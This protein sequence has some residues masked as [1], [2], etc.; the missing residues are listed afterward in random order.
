MHVHNMI[1]P[2]AK[3]VS[4][5]FELF[6]FASLRCPL[7]F[8]F[9]WF[10]PRYILTVIQY[11]QH[12]LQ[13]P[14]ACQRNRKRLLQG[15][16]SGSHIGLSKKIEHDWI[17]IK[18]IINSSNNYQQ[19]SRKHLPLWWCQSKTHLYAM[20]GSMAP[21]LASA[22]AGQ[23][24]GANLPMGSTSSALA[25]PPRLADL[26][27]HGGVRGRDQMVAEFMTLGRP[28]MFNPWNWEWNGESRIFKFGI[29]WE[30]FGMTNGE[31]S[32]WWILAILAARKGLEFVL[33]KDVAH[34]PSFRCSF[35]GGSHKTR[36]VSAWRALCSNVCGWRSSSE[37]SWPGAAVSKVRHSSY[38]AHL[39]HHVLDPWQDFLSVYHASCPPW[40]FSL[41]CGHRSPFL[42]SPRWSCP[43]FSFRTSCSSPLNLFL[44]EWN[45]CLFGWAFLF[46]I[47][48]FMIS[49]FDI[50]LLFTWHHLGDDCPKQ[51]WASLANPVASCSCS[52][53]WNWSP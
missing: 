25:Q 5:S 10:D 29:V 35:A 3:Y 33:W 23:V 40:P 30:C 18:T 34:Q 8:V 32:E 31:T 16:Q 44:F 45:L 14:S 38:C 1:S 4:S 42:F 20:F 47:L 12:I 37:L 21:A 52:C 49:N 24:I 41:P 7:C 50:D 2:N 6:N 11:V 17:I 48:V 46:R 13:K 26:P 19:H 36:Q 39:P 43:L 53:C 27:R 51:S 28:A 22:Y 9:E 15:K